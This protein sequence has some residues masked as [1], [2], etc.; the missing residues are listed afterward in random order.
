MAVPIPKPDTDFFSPVTFHHYTLR[1]EVYMLCHIYYVLLEFFYIC[2]SGY[3]VYA[4]FH[5]TMDIRTHG[6]QLWFSCRPRN[7]E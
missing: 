7:R 2:G 5:G 6:G 3:V 1:C 4:A